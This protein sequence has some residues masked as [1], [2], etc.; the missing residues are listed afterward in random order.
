MIYDYSDTRGMSAAAEA[1]SH[2]QGP[3][4]RGDFLQKDTSRDSFINP[5]I[6]QR[7]RNVSATRWVGGFHIEAY[8]GFFCALQWFII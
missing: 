7:S 5:F 8:P 6:S 1:D 4:A 3:W 2:L